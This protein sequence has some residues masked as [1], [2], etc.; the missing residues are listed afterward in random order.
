[1]H[2]VPLGSYGT[3]DLRT[4]VTRETFSANLPLCEKVTNLT[5]I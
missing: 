1:M 2:F 4:A 3:R 5:D